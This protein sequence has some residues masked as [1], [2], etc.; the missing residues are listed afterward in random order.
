M[1]KLRHKLSELNIR[2]KKYPLYDAAALYWDILRRNDIGAYASQAAFMLMLSFI[3]CVMCL[4]A[5]VTKTG[6]SLATAIEFIEMYFPSSLRNYMT[7]IMENTYSHQSAAILPVTAILAIWLASKAMWSLSQGLDAAYDVQ[8]K[9]N[10]FLHRA[11]CVLYTVIFIAIIFVSLLII[12]FG[13]TVKGYLFAQFPAIEHSLIM[14][15]IHFRYIYGGLLMFLF[16]TLLYSVMPHGKLKF[17]QQIP[18]ALLASVAWVLFSFFYSIYV[19]YF[20]NYVS[21]YGTMTVIALLMLW[22][23]VCMNIL[24]CGAVLNKVIITKKKAFKELLK[25]RKRK[26]NR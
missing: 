14:E 1:G 21:V 3:P 11:L 20:C 26:N 12:V 8:W 7:G 24:F 9:K 5:I 19:D 2:L 13:K 4:L 15:I 17:W 6:I 23:W 18:G 25:S 22:L 16:V 10:Y